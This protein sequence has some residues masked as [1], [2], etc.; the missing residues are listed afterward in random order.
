MWGLYYNSTCYCVNLQTLTQNIYYHGWANQ[1]TWMAH[2]YSNCLNNLTRGRERVTANAVKQA[3]FDQF[4]KTQG[5]ILD[6]RPLK[7]GVWLSERAIDMLQALRQWHAALLRAGPAFVWLA[8]V[9][10]RPR[11]TT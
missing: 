8:N 5:V 1:P 9:H 2:E 10:K 4:P 11:E 6:G 7:C 3:P